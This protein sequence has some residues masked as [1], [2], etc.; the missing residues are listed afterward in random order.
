MFSSNVSLD[1]VPVLAF[2]VRRN[3]ARK[4]G[5]RASAKFS[6]RVFLRARLRKDEGTEGMRLRR[7]APIRLI[8]DNLLCPHINNQ[9]TQRQKIGFLHVV[10]I[11]HDIPLPLDRVAFP[12][13]ASRPAI[14]VKT[15]VTGDNRFDIKIFTELTQVLDIRKPVFGDGF[16]GEEACRLLCADYLKML[17]ARE[18]AAENRS[19]FLAD[20]LRQH[21]ITRNARRLHKRQNS[22]GRIAANVNLRLHLHR[23]RNARD[24]AAT[25][26][27]S[28]GY[29]DYADARADRKT[30]ATTPLQAQTPIVRLHLPESLCG[31]RVSGTADS[32][33]GNIDYPA[34]VWLRADKQQ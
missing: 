25:P 34:R 2:I 16:A 7:A 23:N 24:C 5:K 31:G 3:S 6:Q 15:V 19:D 12:I 11:V 21:L 28:Q 29:E 10:L 18:P 4:L 32:S 30:A 33:V 13:I 14:G 9:N 1:Q 17:L 27:I 8:P 20:A 22:E 26:A